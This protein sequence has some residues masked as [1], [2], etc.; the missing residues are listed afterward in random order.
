MSVGLGFVYK[1]QALGGAGGDRGHT[2]PRPHRHRALTEV[3][4]AAAA[5]GEHAPGN[6]RRRRPRRP[7]DRTATRVRASEPR[8]RRARPSRDER[9]KQQ[10]REE[11][12]QQAQRAGNHQM[13]FIP[14]TAAGLNPARFSS[15]AGARTEPWRAIWTFLRA[16]QTLQSSQSCSTSRTKP[17][18]EDVRPPLYE[19]RA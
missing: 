8:T 19:A 14:P 17:R 3:V 7:V 16:I 2:A 18:S 4:A 13:P 5:P 9:G 15:A 10:T 6:A 12:A 11:Q 1:R